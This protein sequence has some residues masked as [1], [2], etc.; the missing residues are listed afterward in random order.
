MNLNILSAQK[1]VQSAI[2]RPDARLALL[3]VILPV[4]VNL[5]GY[6][7]VGFSFNAF[8]TVLAFGRAI[9]IWLLV[10]LAGYII[11]YLAKG[12]YIRGKFFSIASAFS[13]VW[14]VILIMTLV[15]VI[16]T[17]LIFSRE[18]IEEAR[19]LQV[20]GQSQSEFGERALSLIEQN[21]DSVDENL[22]LA[23]VALTL[24][25]LL[26][27]FYLVYLTVS[28]LAS[29]GFFKN[30]AATL[31]VIVLWIFIATWIFVLL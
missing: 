14:I 12:D 28:D 27:G 3:L 1:C 7:L 16:A 9:L 4:I 6:A 31:V 25:L 20:G 29:K 15:S 17:P 21:P 22:A 23:L 30:L 8:N 18:I 10:S 2:D 19:L 13:L 26:W 24:I 5:V 11:L